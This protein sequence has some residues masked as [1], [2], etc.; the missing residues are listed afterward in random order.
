MA[1]KKRDI[2][3]RNPPPPDP[4]VK[5]ALE[6]ADRILAAIEDDLPDHAWDKAAEFIEDVEAKVKAVQ[7]T[8]SLSKTVS[9]RQQAAL[10]SWESAIGKWIDP[11][12]E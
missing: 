6:Q 10:D 3:P 7:T 12:G 4:D 5:L 2:Q 9:E 1:R 11:R 8:I